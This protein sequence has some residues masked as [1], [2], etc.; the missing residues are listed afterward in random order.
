MENYEINFISIKYDKDFK[1]LLLITLVLKNY[2]QTIVLAVY[3]DINSCWAL[4][5]EQQKNG[6][7]C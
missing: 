6:K 4:N 1:F 7:F 2:V 5:R 3:R